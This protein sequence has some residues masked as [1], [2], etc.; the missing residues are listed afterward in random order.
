VF[1]ADP[2]AFAAVIVDHSMP[3][4]SGQALLDRMLAIAPATRAISF[5]GHDVPMSGARARL[6]KP[7]SIDQLLAAVRDVLDAP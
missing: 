6:A 7:V 3:G 5:S 1:A 2:G 4:L